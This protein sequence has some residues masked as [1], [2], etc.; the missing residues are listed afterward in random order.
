PTIAGID[1]A[2][3]LWSIG[4]KP[5][6]EAAILNAR[7]RKCWRRGKFPIGVIGAPGELRYSYDYLGGGPDTL[8]DLFDGTH[9][10]ADVLK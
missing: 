2:D 9:A 10:F 5:R 1:Q 6:F 4:A 8:K 3:A 7:I